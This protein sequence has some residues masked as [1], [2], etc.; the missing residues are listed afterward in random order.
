MRK[1][2]TRL[3]AAAGAV[4]LSLVLAACGQAVAA[5][6]TADVGTAEFDEGSTGVVNPS[7]HRGGV[8]KFGLRGD[9]DSTDPGAMY[10]AF[11]NNFSRL[12]ARGLLTYASVPGVDGTKPVPDLAVALGEPSDG[13]KTWTYTLRTGIKYENGTEVTAQ[14]VKYAV[15][16]TFDRDVLQSGP[17]YFKTLLDAEGYQGPYK[18]PDLAHFTGVETPD[19]HTVVF[20]LKNPFSEFN[21]LL[22]FSGQTAPVPQAED[23]G[24]DYRLHPLST[25]PYMWDGEYVPGVGGALVH[26][27]HWDAATDPNRKQLPDRIEVTAKV[28]GTEIDARVLSG[29]FHVA[30]TGN[31]L[32][33]AARDTVLGDPVLK[34]RADNPVT[35]FHNYIPVNTKEIPNVEC[36]RAIMYAADRDAM[37]R[38]YGGEIGGEMATSI[39][40]PGIPGRKPADDRHSGRPGY[41]GDVRKAKVALAKC[42]KPRGFATVMTYHGSDADKTAAEALQTSLARV[43]IKVTLKTFDEGSYATDQVGSPAFMAREHIGLATYGWA[44]DWPTGYGF[45]QPVLD[46][47]A[48][49]P[50]GNVNV[51]QL[52]DPR[53]NALWDR[54]IQLEDPAEREKIYNRIDRRAL[55]LGA[56][57]PNIYVKSL[58]YRPDTLTNVYFHQGYNMYDYASLGLSG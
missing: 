39:L 3:T 46:G 58:L 13:N 34:A 44:A 38:A 31:G 32:G 51:S 33:A 25:G 15:A 1:R 4:V 42:G 17:A 37:W 20:R 5:E 8:L 12:Y 23:R 30:M 35:G 40:P 10:Y 22:M 26:N 14:D 21:E 52:D 48:I 57:V 6:N 55:E 47:R 56:L 18:D 49:Q 11:S 7:D 36:R 45:M 24:A 29:E 19:D 2:S 9:F 53:I 16:R 28:K 54:A 27:P 41:H 50:T 43:G